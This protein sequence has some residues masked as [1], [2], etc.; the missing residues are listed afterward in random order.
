MIKSTRC[1]GIIVAIVASIAV[2]HAEAGTEKT[3][4]P[5]PGITR[6]PET[7]PP[8]VTEPPVGIETE[9]PVGIETPP[10]VGTET[11]PPITPFPTPP[12]DTPPPVG[13]SP[14]VGTPPPVMVPI[15]PTVRFLG[16]SLAMINCLYCCSR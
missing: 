7:A 3:L 12:G 16:F 10:P 1:L 14:P 6:P 11:P 5:T 15:P 4:A 8:V 13:T 9:P 2:D